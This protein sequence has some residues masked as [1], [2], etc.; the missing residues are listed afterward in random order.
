[1]TKTLKQFCEEMCKEWDIEKGGSI[2]INKSNCKS[3][4]CENCPFNSDK[5]NCNI[6]FRLMYKIAHPE[7]KKCP[8]CDGTGVVK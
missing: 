8:H 1:M 7:S 6:Q 5:T 3:I 2:N 4:G